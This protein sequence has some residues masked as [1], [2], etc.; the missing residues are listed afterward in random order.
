MGSII[1]SHKLWNRLIIAAFTIQLFLYTAKLLSWMSDNLKIPIIWHLGIVPI[2]EI[3]LFTQKAP[4]LKQGHVQKILSVH[5]LLWYLLT[6]C[7]I[8][9]SNSSAMKT[10]ENTEDPDDPE[11]Y[12]GDTQMQYT[13]IKC[14]TQVQV[15]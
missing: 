5:Q 13:L 15:Q 3:L 2:P 7:L 4:S 8:L 6:S 14:T 9:V 12:E 1:E 11:S 10:P